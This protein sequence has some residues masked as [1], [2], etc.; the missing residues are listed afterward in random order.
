LTNSY[1]LGIDSFF[2]HKHEPDKSIMPRKYLAGKA[3]PLLIGILADILIWGPFPKTEANAHPHI[4]IVQRLEI[5]FDEK[6][7]AGINIRWKLDDMFASM[8]AED[9]DRNHNGTL[10]PAEVLTVKEKAFSYI[11]EHSYF[12]FVKIE[13]KPFP[14]KYITEFNAVLRDKRLEYHFFVPC[15]VKATSNVKKVTVAT[16]DP[17]YYSAVFFAKNGPVSLTAA[18][19]YEVKTAIREDPSTTI[20]YGMVH[21]WTLF[22]EFCQKP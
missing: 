1:R 4:F 17:T 15:H 20:Y 22:L 11:A 10:E 7:L 21:P 3:I 9:H 19:P 8:I 2:S 5:V 14:V 16:Y 13:N 18:D 6:G 12:I